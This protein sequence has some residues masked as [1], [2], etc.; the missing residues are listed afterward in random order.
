MRLKVEIDTREHFAVLGFKARRFQLASPW[1][2]GE[3]E[4]TTYRLEELLGTKLRALY[5]RRKGRDLFDFWLALRDHA[6]DPEEAVNC[7]HRYLRHSNLTT[8]RA[9]FE[10][11]LALKMQDAAF[12]EDVRPC[13]RRTPTTIR[14][15]PI[16]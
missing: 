7:F 13:C 10:R 16:R 15:K 14:W 12:L 6:V 9:H 2:S 4:I 11:N 3:T 1:V 8:S 5:Q